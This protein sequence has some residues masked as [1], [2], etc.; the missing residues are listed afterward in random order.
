MGEKFEIGF[1]EFIRS[2]LGGLE[3]RIAKQF[4]EFETRTD[5]R[6][7]EMEARTDKRLDEKFAIVNEKFSTITEQF[8]ELKE[9]VRWPRRIA[10][11]GVITT[12]IAVVA[13]IIGFNV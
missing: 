4:S 3:S 9:E 8:K 7:L 11:G 13:A 5:R 12:V 6:F 10:I 2:E 1:Y